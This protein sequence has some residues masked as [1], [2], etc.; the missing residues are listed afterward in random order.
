MEKSKMKNIVVIK[1]L[2]SNLIE[3]ALIVV[4]SKKVARNLEYIDRKNSLKKQEEKNE[5]Y[6]IREAES[7]LNSYVEHIEKR[8]KASKNIIGLKYKKIKIYSVIITI[9]FVLDIITRLVT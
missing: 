5:N 2:P 6:I 9:L 1:N 4:K 8:E 3:E 7:V